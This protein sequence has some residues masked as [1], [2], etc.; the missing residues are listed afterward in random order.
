LEYKV[1]DHILF[2]SKRVSSLKKILIKL[3]SIILGRGIIMPMLEGFK[4]T[5]YFGG[6][7]ALKEIDFSLEKGEILGLIGPNGAGKTTLFNVISGLYKPTSGTVKFEDRI[8]TKLK[9]HQICKLGIA[10]TFQIVNPFLNLTVLENVAVGVLFGRNEKTSVEKARDIA[11]KYLEFVNLHSRKYDYAKNLNIVERKQ[12]EI[13]RALAIEPKLI[14]LDEPLCGLNPTEIKNACNL[15]RRIRD[16][17]N[18]TVF[19]IE[20]VMKAIMGTAERIIVL[21][22]GKKIAE[23]TPLEISR[24]KEVIA[25]YLGEKEA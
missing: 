10:R 7:P 21:D 4:I 14:L 5:K 16:E 2:E 24:N 13:A 19:W 15:I 3:S 8:I 20:H 23:G 25:A 22:S 9:P 18:I 11:F 6:L 1:T 12:L 17:L